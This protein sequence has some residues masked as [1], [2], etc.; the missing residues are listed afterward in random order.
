MV[1][2]LKRFP[3]SYFKPAT[4]ITV[5]AKQF[6]KIQRNAPLV[7]RNLSC[8]AAAK[9]WHLGRRSQDGR[10]RGCF[11]RG[12]AAPTVRSSGPGTAG[13][14]RGCVPAREWD[15]LS[16]TWSSQVK[17]SLSNVLWSCDRLIV[18]TKSFDRFG[19]Y[20]AAKPHNLSPNSALFCHWRDE[21]QR[22]LWWQEEHRSR[23]KSD[24]LL[25][26]LLHLGL[27]CSKLNCFK[28]I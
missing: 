21:R 13:P 24:E 11:S 14:A 10:W 15:S 5:T 17:A 4:L 2:L 23:N 25:K 1:P 7:F 6:P 19:V 26:L 20:L 28:L 9:Q 18:A 12:A 22:I 8:S 27:D 3:K 16:D